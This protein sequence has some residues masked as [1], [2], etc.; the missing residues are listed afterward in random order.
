MSSKHSRDAELALRI[1]D[2]DESAFATVVEEH[3]PAVSSVARRVLR[4]RAL[5]QDVTQDT[6]TRLWE[7]PEKYDARRGTLRAF[8]VTVAHRRSIDVVRAEVARTRRESLPPEPRHY[9]VEEEVWSQELSQA[10]REALAKLPEKEREVISLAYFSAMTYVE[11]ARR[12]D[13]PEGTV[14]TRIRT[15]MKKM[16]TALASVK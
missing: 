15:G 8:L 16:A 11:V 5:A 14:K 7:V 12:L 2:R 9:S 3:T 1:V 10:V 13:L 6:F 4:N